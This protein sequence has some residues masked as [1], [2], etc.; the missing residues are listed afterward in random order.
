[1]RESSRERTVSNVLA[2]LARVIIPRAGYSHIEHETYEHCYDTHND[3]NKETYATGEGVVELRSHRGDDSAVEQYSKNES[4]QDASNHLGTARGKE[5][6]H[7]FVVLA[8][9]Y[10][11]FSEEIMLI[12]N[13]RISRPYVLYLKS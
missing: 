4:G 1:M 12:N 10:E 13:S 8:L 6:L 5:L 3:E 11:S 9:H 7:N 2:L